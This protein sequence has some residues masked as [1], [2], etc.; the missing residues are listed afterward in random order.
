MRSRLGILLAL[1]AGC[2]FHAVTSGND[3]G[4]SGGASGSSG[5]GSG[6]GGNAGGGGNG[7]NGGG[8]N[9]GSSGGDMA[10]GNGDPSCPL[11][12][13]LVAVQSTLNGG[14][15]GRIA[16][17]SLASGQPTM[18]ALRDGH[19]SIDAL[20]QTIT[21]F[22]GKIA[23]AS[24]DHVYAVD[25]GQDV[26]SWINPVGSLLSTPL[27]ID[28]FEL[29]DPAGKPLVAVATALATSNPVV[30]QV[31]VFTSD[32]KVP[33][34]TPWCMQAGCDQDLHLGLGIV[35][36]TADPMAPTHLLALDTGT[37]T[38]AWTVDPYVPSHSTVVGNL[39]RPLLGL[40][41]VGGATRRYVWIVGGSPN[42][43]IYTSD[44]GGGI[45]NPV[46]CAS[47]CDPILHAVPDP[48]DN[49]HFFL[50]CDSDMPDT[51]R[52]VRVDTSGKCTTVLAGSALPASTRMARLGLAR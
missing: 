6:G 9:G 16:R 50:L 52:V 31:D 13:L 11:P 19:K 3:M 47:G 12:Q 5:G 51:R 7:G 17:L 43:I 37:D 38:A 41:A 24:A 29:Q 26:V 28:A 48:T 10:M 21:G 2:G 32:G 14:G 33:A 23:I 35:G 49:D 45:Q 8:G 20:P 22:A 42:A 27:G 44:V 39:S 34:M 30:R 18:C 40:Y 1:L 25:P 46:Y 4:G 36:M 15:Y